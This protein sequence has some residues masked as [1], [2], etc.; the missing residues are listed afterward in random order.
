MARILAAL[1]LLGLACATPVPTNTLP[2]VFLG[3]FESVPGSESNFAEFA[4]VFRLPENVKL[5]ERTLVGF[6]K[7]GDTYHQ[8]FFFP[9]NQKF[10]I[11]LPFKL[12]EKQTTTINGKNVEYEFTAEGDEHT[13]T[14][15]AKLREVDGDIKFTVEAVFT[16]EGYNATYTRENIVAKR[17]Y[18]RTLPWYVLGAYEMDITKSDANIAEFYNGFFPLPKGLTWT[19]DTKF[20]VGRH[21]NKFYEKFMVDATYYEKVEFELNK[22]GSLTHGN[23]TVEYKYEVVE[24]TAESTTMRVTYKCPEKGNLVFTCVFDREGVTS[25][26]KSEK[27]NTQVKARYTRV[28]PWLYYGKFQEVPEKTENFAE[29]LQGSD[30]PFDNKP[31]TLEFFRKGD[32]Y[33]ARKTFPEGKKINFDFKLNTPQEFTS[34]GKTFKY[35]VSVQARGDKIVLQSKIK[36]TGNDK[37]FIVEETVAPEGL[38]VTYKRDDVVA[39]KFLRRI[40]SKT[41]VG[42]F[43]STDLNDEF[44]AFANHIEAP[45]FLKKL[46]SELVQNEDGTI[47]T[48]LT[49]EGDAV[50]ESRMTFGK[51][52]ELTV[53]G[54]HLEHKAFYFEVDTPVMRCTVNQTDNANRYFETAAVFRPDGTGYTATFAYD[55]NTKIA[56]RNF[57]RKGEA[58][59]FVP[60]Q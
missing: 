37:V 1:A 35:N 26:A 59:P 25:T 28:L 40:V 22:P 44:K 46:T 57:V 48:K 3:L 36:V 8:R 9:S 17:T 4:K 21:G 2:K 29:F 43:E 56:R 51:N 33:G 54:K 52:E 50:Q 45:E 6:R 47:T 12:G 38:Y 39:K 23:T 32:H 11:D 49:P 55:H 41:V 30:C 16:D 18:R 60:V 34:E 7:D 58:V 31:Y 53:Y 19:K 24:S 42:T 14:F 27:T 5:E 20:Y 13:G 15:H 10:S